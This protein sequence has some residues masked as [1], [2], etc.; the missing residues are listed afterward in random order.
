M[1]RPFKC[2]T[3]YRKEAAGETEGLKENQY[4]IEDYEQYPCLL[5]LN[6][7]VMI[8]P[9]FFEKKKVTTVYFKNGEKIF[10]FYPFDKFVELLFEPEKIYAKNN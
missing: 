8:D 1:E 10:A 5:D 4:F 9:C 3:L 6:Q 2:T 7:I